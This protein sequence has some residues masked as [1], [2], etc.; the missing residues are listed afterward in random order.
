MVTAR[1]EVQPEPGP[2]DRKRRTSGP[3]RAGDGTVD[4]ESAIGI[5]TA[6]AHASTAVPVAAPADAVGLVLDRLRGQTFDTVAAVAVCTRDLLVGMVTIERLLAAEPGVTVAEVMDADPPTVAP[7]TDQ[8][9]VAWRAVQH[10]ETALAVVDGAGRFRGLVPPQ[11][12]LAVLLAEH[13]EDIARL[14]G[15]LGSAATARSAATESVRLRLWHRL[16]WLLVGLAGALVAAVIV[17]AFERQLAEEVLIA[18]FIPGVV[19]LADAVGTQTEAL[20]IRGLAAGVG[21]GRVAAREALTG[22]L[23]GVL[24]AAVTYPLVLL[25]WQDPQ[26]AAAVAVALFA[27][28]S[29]ATLVALVLPWTLSRL[30][31]DP[32]FGSGPLATVVQD[33]LSIVIY[34]L[35]VLAFVT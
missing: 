10:G 1:A 9:Q 4:G 24:F 31:R 26:V 22:V 20:V 11:R 29:L 25:L 28:S 6:A 21:I 23:L 16:P 27:A 2:G 35:A 12:L 18:F 17:G 15:F 7:G 34:F 8:E 30:G 14:G 3:P 13:D 33:L 19:Y 5:R 32:A